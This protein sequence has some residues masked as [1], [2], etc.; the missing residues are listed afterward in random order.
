MEFK[1][2]IRNGFVSNSS[3]SSFV[4]IAKKRDKEIPVPITYSNTLMIPRNLS[5]ETEFGSNSGK[6]SDF[7]SKLNFLI[8]QALYADDIN[9]I[10]F[11]YQI[12]RQKFGNI[13]IKNNLRLDFVDF[14]DGDDSEELDKIHFGSIDHQSIGEGFLEFFEGSPEDKK[15]NLAS[16]AYSLVEK[17]YNFLFMNDSYLY[18]TSDGC[19][20]NDMI[21]KIDK[22]KYWIITYY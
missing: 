6:Y 13:D 11:I 22:E 12:L 1:M 5:G 4:A 17:M 20:I 18:F 3:S 9:C 15:K 14:D 16:R 21:K 19:D 8:L 2:K 10:S 7:D